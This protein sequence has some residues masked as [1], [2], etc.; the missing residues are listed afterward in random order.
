[1]RKRKYECDE[2]KG[3]RKREIIFWACG[4]QSERDEYFVREET[5]T[6]GR[7]YS[8]RPILNSVV[9]WLITNDHLQLTILKNGINDQY[10]HSRRF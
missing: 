8:F 2:G 1:M 5:Q 4:K 6:I 10:T 9:F 3:W 7:C